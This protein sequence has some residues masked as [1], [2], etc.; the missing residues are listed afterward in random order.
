[1][2]EAQS[3]LPSSSPLFPSTPLYSSSSSS[4][5]NFQILWSS[6]EKFPIQIAKSSKTKFLLNIVRKT[7]KERKLDFSNKNQI[8]LE[9]VDN[10]PILDF[11]LS[12]PES[13]L[14]NLG[15]E[16]EEGW[17]LRVIRT[18]GKGGGKVRGIDFKFVRDLGKKE[19]TII[20]MGKL[21]V[22]KKK[23]KECI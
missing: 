18:E 10:H 21:L 14:E 4:L 17:T 22:N 19:E 8:G 6:D 2:G 5:L 1:M 23:K 3:S 9:S 15:E 12:S 16:R 11:L 13:L 7:A 20:R